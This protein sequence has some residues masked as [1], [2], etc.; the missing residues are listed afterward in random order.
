MIFTL[1]EEVNLPA[2]LDSLRWCDDV[3]VVDS[4]SNDGTEEIARS[5]GARFFQHP[6]QGFGSQRNWALANTAPR[7]DWV[8]VLDADEKVPPELAN[9]LVEIARCAPP[10]IGAYRVRRRFYMWGRWLKRSSLYPTWVV[11]FVRRG[12]VRYVDRGH[13]ETQEV[14]GET[15]DLAHDLIDGNLKGIDEW[16]E[17]QNRYS[18]KEADYE[19]EEEKG[20]LRL[21]DLGSADPLRRRAALKRLAS[22]L[23]CRP[24]LYFLYIYLL[25]GG[26][27]EGKD[28]YVFCRMKADYQR[29]IDAKK[30]DRRRRESGP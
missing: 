18:R 1:N 24:F 27:L 12:R 5:R 22:R 9:E 3:I 20:S 4:F 19:I 30:Y 17:R 25:R 29:M 2:C 13:A 7:H 14:D 21:M 15:G 28:G 26:F 23:P 11:R 16:F 10:G 8:L 6:F